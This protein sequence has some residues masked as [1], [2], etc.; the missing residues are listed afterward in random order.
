[1]AAPSSS[2]QEGQLAA[3]PSPEGKCSCWVCTGL[4]TPCRE[5]RASTEAGFLQ[6]DGW[7]QKPNFYEKCGEELSERALARG[8]PCCR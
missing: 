7:E 5:R 2:E 4:S 6:S 3:S 1:M 8:K